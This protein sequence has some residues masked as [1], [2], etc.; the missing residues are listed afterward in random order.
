M[1][2]VQDPL[3]LADRNMQDSHIAYQTFVSDADALDA[4]TT[5]WYETHREWKGE[6]GGPALSDK[7]HGYWRGI[8]REVYD[9][10]FRT[11]RQAYNDAWP[12]PQEW[13]PDP[14]AGSGGGG[15]G[16]NTGET[17]QLRVRGEWFETVHGGRF[18][19]ICITSFVLNK[20]SCEGTDARPWLQQVRDMGFN[21][22]RDF[23]AQEWGDPRYDV[24]PTTHPDYY[25]HLGETAQ[26]CA[27]HG[28]YY[29][30]CLFGGWQP[31]QQEQLDHFHRSCDAL[32]PYQNVLI[33]LVNEND[34]S[35]HLDTSIFPRPSGVLAS[36]GS[37]G[38]Q[39]LAVRPPWD[40]EAFHTNGAPE[41]QRKIGHNAME[42]SHGTPDWPASH[43][44]TITNET[45]RYPEV[46]MWRN[47]DLNRQKMLAYDSAAGAALLCAGSCYHS[48]NAKLC[49]RL[50]HEEEQVARAWVDGA[51]SVPLEYQDGR[52]TASH[53]VGIE[54]EPNELR[55]YGRRLNDGRTHWVS[56]H[57]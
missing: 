2:R 17:P 54:L 38:S 45:S 20:F 25:R 18:T 8:S 48:V 32:R 7:H 9:L 4:F 52:Y 1:E 51:R 35:G 5:S 34:A 22:V 37:N 57:K 46:G 6:P 40:W 16:G 13:Q 12:L 56:I 55:R 50:G 24:L 11:L 47:A 33:E 28:L 30:A 41:E 49:L 44:P 3:G 21:M 36:H 26:R 53:L 27:E 14:F 29:M 23:S 10:G 15:G 31:S 43:V 42:L 39:A 19:V